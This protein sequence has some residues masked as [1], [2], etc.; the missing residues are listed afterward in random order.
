MLDNAGAPMV[1]WGGLVLVFSLAVF[2]LWNKTGT[3]AWNVLWFLMVVIGYGIERF[4][5]GKKSKGI[6][7]FIAVT[8]GKVWGVFGILAVSVPTLMVLCLYGIVSV[9][10]ASVLPQHLVYVPI[11]VLIVALLGCSTAVT[12]WILKNGWITAVGF[13]TGIV[14]TAFAVALP[15]AHQELILTGVSLVGLILP[16][17]IINK[18]GRDE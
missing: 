9:L 11:T 5:K 15:G 8:L 14:G 1:T 2:F 18:G 4:A 6:H 17:L 10:P 13:L 16:G 3:P 7:S 12:G